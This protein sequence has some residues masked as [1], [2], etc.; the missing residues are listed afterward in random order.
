MS[1]CFV[2]GRAVGGYHSYILFYT[3]PTPMPLFST[4]EI[5]VLFLSI[6][7]C[8]CVA[9]YV[10]HAELEDARCLQCLRLP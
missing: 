5:Q 2:G 4:P 1:V 7:F 8:V 6:Y 3:N 9:C 10:N